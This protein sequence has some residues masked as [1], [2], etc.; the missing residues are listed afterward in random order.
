MFL[1]PHTGLNR[2]C[3]AAASA[4]IL[5]LGTL[6]SGAS[7]F[8]S[9]PTVDLPP[10]GTGV[11]TY[12]DAHP[13]NPKNRDGYDAATNPLPPVVINSP[14]I[15]GVPG[16]VVDLASGGSIISAITSAK[17]VVNGKDGNVTVRLAPGGTYAGFTMNGLHN[18]HIICPSAT[19]SPDTR[20]IIN[21]EINIT[22]GLL[23]G[24]TGLNVS[25]YYAAVDSALDTDATGA[26]EAWQLFRN[27]ASNIYF[28]NIRIEHTSLH[29]RLWRVK[30]VLFDNCTF[31]SRYPTTAE[32]HHRGSIIGAMGNRNVAFLNCDF[33]GDSENVLYLDG[34]QCAVIHNC[35]FKLDTNSTA[36]SGY[37]SGPLFLCNDDFTEARTY[38]PFDKIDYAEE[39]NAKY[40]VICGNTYTGNAQFAAAVTGEGLLFKDNTVAS[41]GFNNGINWETRSCSSGR[42]KDATF[43]Y[44]YQ[45]A[46]VVGNNFGALYG[47]APSMV[48]A[49]GSGMNVYLSSFYTNDSLAYMS[50]CRIAGN[51]AAV[52]TGG[53]AGF[54]YLKK[55]IP[56]GATSAT[57]PVGP[58][59]TIAGSTS[60]TTWPNWAGPYY[61]GVEVIGGNRLNGS[62][63]LDSA[64][65]LDTPP[66][67]APS[68][69][70]ASANGTT[71]IDLAW[72]DNTTE[73]ASY[74]VERA[75]N[76]AGPFTLVADLPLKRTSY[77]DAGLPSGATYYYRVSAVN[78]LGSSPSGTASATV[79]TPTPAAPVF[80]LH[81]SSQTVAAGT[82][83]TFTASST[84]V[85]APAYQWK[86]DGVNIDG[87]T[88]SSLTITNVQAA[89]TGSYTV[90]ATNTQG[91]ATSNPAT[92]NIQVPPSAPS[93]L[94]ATAASQTAINLAWTDNSADETGFKVERATSSGGPWTLLATTAAN[95][96]TYAS[97]GLAGSTT[98]FFRVAATRSGMDSAYSPT[99]SATTFSDTAPPAV[100]SAAASSAT[101]VTVTFSEAVDATTANAAE[102]YSI[103]GLSVSSAVRQSNT[104]VVLLTVSG[105]AA[106]NYTLTVSGVKDVAG[107]MIVSSNQAS[108]TYTEVPSS[109]LL[110]WFKSDAGITQSGGKVS[111]WADQ[112][113]NADNST[114]ATAAS[115]PTIVENALN[116]KPV[117]RFDGTD[118]YLSF[119]TVAI[120]GLNGMTIVMVAANAVNQNPTTHAHAAGIYWD[121]TASWGTAYLS[122]YQSK[123][124][125]RFG[126]GQTNNL[127]EYTRP[128]SLG[129]G[130]SITAAVHNATSETLYVNGASVLTQ[131][132]KLAAIANCKDS[133]FLGR[134]YA[135]T[136]FNGDIAEVMV[137]NR[138]LTA[139]EL[140]AV[141]S[142]LAAKYFHIGPQITTQ[143]ASASVVAGD[144]V[145]FSVTATGNP[146]PAFQWRK[147]GVNISGATGA[148]YT[149]AG[150]QASDQATYT[151]VASNSVGTVV[152]DGATLTVQSAGS[153]LLP[154]NTTSTWQSRTGSSWDTSVGHDALGSYKVVG[155]NSNYT[156][157]LNLSPL[158]ADTDY[159]LRGWVK[160]QGV[161]A[162][163]GASIGFYQTVGATASFVSPT[164]VSE[165]V[166]TELV[167]TFR[168]AATFSGGM[169]RL[170]WNLAAGQTAWF[171]DVSL[172]PIGAAVTPPSAA[173]A[174]AAAPTSGSGDTSVTITWADTS[175]NEDGFRV[176]TAGAA[177]GSWASAGSVAANT[178]SV[179]VTG[180]APLTRYFFRVVAFNGGGD[181][182]P[183][184][185][186]SATTYF[187]RSPG[188]GT[189]DADGSGVPDFL[190]YALG[191]SDA[192]T[193]AANRP[194]PVL[195]EQA[196][197]LAISFQRPNPAPADA[198]YQLWASDDLASWSRVAAPAATVTANGPADTVTLKDSAPLTG[199]AKR[200]LKLV[201]VQI[202]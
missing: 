182:T 2:F 17:S 87:A 7:P 149:I 132:G 42:V 114:Q 79:G 100:S 55:A 174:I 184:G 163:Y 44:H 30:D 147:D 28:H 74:W 106:G 111:A 115:Q 33:K 19:N 107:N 61:N 54:Q 138:A 91:S 58:F 11:E 191:I 4:G 178:T 85:P 99:A 66:P 141:N 200:F 119:S 22:M 140:A 143:P 32:K 39:L 67:A 117:V 123:I 186:I 171:D 152:S 103:P 8:N 165:G 31:K 160:T 101:Q 84:G 48:I 53:V 122:P 188:A 158:S 65:G 126:T 144:P 27:P 21:G 45:G 170:N 155:A 71:Q 83:V 121:E 134:G 196:D 26:G 118:D 62:G 153:S 199:K 150:A 104:A 70:V 109:G 3:L 139:E 25:T 128:E 40:I 24:M 73:E 166:W 146:E 56:V 1:S 169:L 185:A 162:G 116:G 86:K 175:N 94:S 52:S 81:P 148:T 172:S 60:S 75:T 112:S 129:L 97:T 46:V 110:L 72:S 177:S 14:G 202:P 159:V 120:N 90:V 43:N 9:V 124:R 69:L 38:A 34:T 133:G 63:T 78:F 6:S 50:G 105:M 157:A 156:F 35:T 168:T 198:E 82:N 64:Y 108:F 36:P 89:N 68:N 151:V 23:T 20:P 161:T 76:P 173:S 189:A 197:R 80:T 193:L 130:F 92:L 47:T 154:A 131:T 16:T 13:Y 41:G 49:N 192:A 176:E 77:Q 195:D 88:S 183:S 180:L 127:P 10:R 190:E 37:N 5:V 201:I 57:S 98:Y 113:A 18:V 96:A 135:T 181:A 179:A 194:V 51:T 125:Y 145:T 29:S 142:Y 59:P 12:W 164:T 93:G 187:S 136:Y 95:A 167:V 102:N 15:N 137:Y